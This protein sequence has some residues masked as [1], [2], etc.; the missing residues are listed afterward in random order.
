MYILGFIAIWLGL[1][2][3]SKRP[4]SPLKASEIEDLVF[5]GALGVFI[6]GRLGYVLFYMVFYDLPGLVADPLSVFYIHEGGMSFHGGLIGVMIAMFVFARRRG[7]T[8][9]TVLDEMAPWTAPGLFFGRIGNFINGELWGGVTDVPWAIVYDGEPRHPSQLYEAVLEGIVLFAV[10]VWFQA[11][12]RPRMAMSGLFALLY[13][14]FRIGIEFIRVPDEGRYLAF[15]WLTRGQL[16]S[17][18]LVVVGAV[19]LY[20][21]YRRPRQEARA[22]A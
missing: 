6:G 10:L 9:F 19:L 8:L 20:L 5:F 12:P 17:A 7:H 13:G 4:G 11:K 21:A 2:W 1:R 14:V 16:Y 22:A 15:G 18:P 3:R